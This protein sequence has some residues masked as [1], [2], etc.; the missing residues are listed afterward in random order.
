MSRRTRWCL[1]LAAL[2]L[3]CG[4]AQAQDAGAWT[5]AWMTSLQSIPQREA[6]PPLYQAP[7]VAGR[8]VRQV[9][10]PT[11]A[12]D[13]I[14]LHVSN[15]YA[16]TPLDIQRM[17]VARA[18]GGNAA[19]AD[20]GVAV[21]FGGQPR[22]RLPPGGEADSDPLPLKV[23][24]H[25]PYAIS[26]LLG[27]GQRLQAWHRVA[28]QTSYVSA[29]GDHTQ[30]TAADA[31]RVHFT[32]FAWV[33][34]LAVTQAP[35]GAVLAIGDSITDG[36]RSTPG[37]N[38]RWP[39]ALSRRLGENNAHAPAVLNAGIS[40]NRLLSDSPCYGERLVGRFERELSAQP[41]VRTVI[42]LIGINDINFAA[43]PP[44]RGL[45]CDEPHT[46]VNADALIAGYRRLI[47]TA[48][49][50]HVRVLLGTLTPAALPAPRESLRLAVN[51][52]MRNTREADGVVDFDAALRDPAHPGSLRASYDSGDH[53]HPSDAGYAAMAQAVPL[54]LLNAP[55]H[56]TAAH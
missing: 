11:L 46:A 34:S 1:H 40:G 42:V 10:Y 20:A 33:D 29:P 39:D 53:I 36:M 15:H 52:W 17:R 31:Y 50:H 22:L 7:D 37:T 18:S 47:D 9:V 26:T 23:A 49:R 5:A 56:S 48:R 38:R 51:Q 43:M 3:I 55:N 14:R 25:Q 41:G 13:S 32:Q 2:S 28:S 21:T 6:L 4:V 54:S 30:D 19:T 44:H 16:S 35:A 12:G 8:T 45:D 24:S 27:A